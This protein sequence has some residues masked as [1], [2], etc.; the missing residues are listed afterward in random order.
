[1]M[2]WNRYGEVDGQISLFDY[3][4]HQYRITNKIRLIELFAGIG[5][6]AMALRDIGADFEH[7]FVCEFDKYAIASYNAIHETDFETS[8]IREV[9]AADLNIV[10]RDKYTYICFYSFPCQDLSVAGLGKGMTDNTTRSGLLWEVKRIFDE[11]DGNLPHICIM[12]NVPNIHSKKNMPDFQRWLDYME[13]IGYSNYWKDLNAID[14]GI[15]Q[16]RKRTFCVSILGD[17]DY[18]FPWK[19]PL[20]QC[21]YNRLEPEVDDKF[22]KCSDRAKQLIDKWGADWIRE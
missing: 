11:C 14:Y 1:M 7:H 16:S 3:D 18:K 15:P 21:M 4:K 13:S 5:A 17:Y 8:D 12:E 20:T 9:H 2:D 22:Y 6:Q 10:E 19:I